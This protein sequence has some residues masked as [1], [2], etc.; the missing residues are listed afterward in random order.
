MHVGVIGLGAGT[1][2]AY[3][4]AGD[5]FRIYD[6][7]PAVIKIAYTSFT[8]LTDSKAHIEVPLGDARLSL[9]REPAQNFDLLAVDAFS[10]DAIPVHLLTREAFGVYFHH[11]KDTGVLAM[12]ISNRH[13]DLEPVMDMAATAYGKKTIVIETEDDDTAEVSSATWVLLT[14][15]PG[16]FEE[17]LISKGATQLKHTT[18]LR[19]WTDD[20]S[21]L[22][23]ILKK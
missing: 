19:P 14:N 21:N 15:R 8:Y 10:S 9:E 6:I 2:A 11:L 17:P 22:F 20:Y 1:L 18:R 12:H 4:R 3:G 16:F 23:Q 5:A 7:N 13:L